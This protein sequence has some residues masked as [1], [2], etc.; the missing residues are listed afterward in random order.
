MGRRRSL[1]GRIAVLEQRVA[2]LEAEGALLRA[3]FLRLPGRRRPHYRRHERMDILWHAARYG[4][5]IEK[6]AEVFVVTP[7]TFLNW[8]RVARRKEPHLLPPLRGLPELVHDLVRRLKAEWPRWGTRRIA[9]QLARLGLKA[10]RSSVQRILRRGPT[11]PA[12]SELVTASRGRVLLVKCPDHIWMID[13]TK[14]DGV[15]RPLWIGAVIDAFSRRVIAIAAVRGAPSSAFAVRLLRKAIRKNGVPRWLVTDKDPVLRVGLVQ[16]L[17]TSHGILRRYGAVGR[18]GSIAL[19]ERTWRS[20]K[21]EYVRHLFLHR[22][23]RAL[24]ARLRRW[25]RWNNEHR[26]H[27]GLGQRTPDDVYRGR[28]P[29]KVRNQTAGTLQV[30]FLDGDHRLPV[31]QLRRAA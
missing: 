14:I 6:A 20:L 30:R 26:P 31:L 9:G 19:I 1:A 25:A 7:Q 17:L 5:S 28:R 21:T 2:C 13:F 23:V 18:K 11:R 10:S 22:P 12:E 24:E 3:R 8:Q 27:Q 29:R 16:R 4:L 15:V